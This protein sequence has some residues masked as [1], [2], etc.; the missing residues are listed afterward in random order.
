MMSAF[1]RSGHHVG[2]S[3][4]VAIT[5]SRSREGTVRNLYAH[6]RTRLC[7][8]VTVPTGYPPMRGIF[9]S[10]ITFFHLAMSAL[11]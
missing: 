9:A 3:A 2:L 7:P 6:L 8:A 1:G 10:S 4:S 11:I 5:Q